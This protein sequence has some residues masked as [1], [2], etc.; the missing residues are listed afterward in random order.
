MVE[1]SQD[2]VGVGRNLGNKLFTYAVGSIIAK[3]LGYALKLPNKSFI[4]RAG[5]IEEFPFSGFKGK[6][7]TSPFISCYDGSFNNIDQIVER[8]KGKKIILSGYYLRYIN[9]KEDKK[10]VKTLYSSLT[11][12]EYEKDSTIILLRN[13][14][15]DRTFKLPESYYLQQIEKLNVKKLYISYDHYEEHKSLIDK[16]SKF[17][18]EILN[19]NILQLFKKVTSME[20][21]I[22]SQGTFSFWSCFL[23]KAKQIIWPITK[24][25]PNKTSDPNVN[26]VVDDEDRYKFIN[27]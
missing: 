22:A 12:K 21:I 26:L 23:S 11:E 7:I 20:T 5:I 6:E 8:G 25:G 15:Q 4:Q 9:I 18:P 10:F 27:V 14:R 19:L 1:I 13:S 17:N 3:R 24:I 2:F 16:L